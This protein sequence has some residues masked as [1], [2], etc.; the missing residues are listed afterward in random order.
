MVFS[1][2]TNALVLL[3]ARHGAQTNAPALYLTSGE[4]QA[5][6]WIEAHTPPAALILCAPDTGLLIPAHTG[7]RV[8]YGHPY[9]T[10]NA[11]AEEEAVRQ[12]FSGGVPDA[13]AFLQQRGV[14]YVFY[15]PREGALGKLPEG[16]GLEA[17]YS[18][19]GV[20]IYQAAGQ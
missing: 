10:A 14:E 19:G 17:V 8:L 6:E 18:A 2:L 4:A 7:R 20:T 13:A 16:L 5:F 11:Q 15:G 9:E 1:L 12:F 3:A